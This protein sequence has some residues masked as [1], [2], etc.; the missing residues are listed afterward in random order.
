MLK[1]NFNGNV[2]TLSKNKFDESFPNGQFK[3]MAFPL[4]TDETRLKME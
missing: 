4:C 2:K 3:F 1:G